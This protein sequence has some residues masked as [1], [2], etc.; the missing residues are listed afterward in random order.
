M[1]QAATYSVQT[2]LKDGTPIQIRALH[3]SDEADMLTAIARTGPQS[4][5]SRFFILK[6]HFS[7][8]ERAYFMDVDFVN[9]VAL[10]ALAEEQG[11]DAIIGGGRYVVVEPGQAEMAFVVVDAWQGRGVGSLL[12][13]HL[14][15]IA[16]AQGVRELTAEVLSDNSPMRSV[17]AK[18]GFKLARSD[19]PRTV[20]LSLPL[21]SAR[22]A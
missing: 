10:A 15:D 11:R 17:F 2:V 9:H 12:L 22:P 3:A 16:R 18:A 19:D 6:R 5:Q 20:H 7:E 1:S 4:L 21:G 13:R 8:K 14:T